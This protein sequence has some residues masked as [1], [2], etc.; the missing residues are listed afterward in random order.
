MFSIPVF[1]ATYKT[2]KKFVSEIFK[3]TRSGK[4]DSEEDSLIEGCI[5]P[6]IQEKYN[7]TTKN[8]PVDHSYMVLL[9]KKICGI[10]NKCCPFSN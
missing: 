4:L 3:C 6:E 5:K 9:L 8:G 7:I 2:M 1:T 10:K